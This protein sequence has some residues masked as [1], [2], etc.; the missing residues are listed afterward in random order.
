MYLR[1]L[2]KG[3]QKLLRKPQKLQS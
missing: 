1:K 3:N 2:R